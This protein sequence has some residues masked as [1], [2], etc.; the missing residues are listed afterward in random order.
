MEEIAIAVSCLGIGF[1]ARHYLP[2]LKRFRHQHTFNHMTSDGRWRCGVC[3]AP[4][5]KGS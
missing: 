5:K 3:E 4:K 2:Y 1:G